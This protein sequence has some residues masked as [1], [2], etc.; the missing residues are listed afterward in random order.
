VKKRSPRKKTP[1]AR[2]GSRE[3]LHRGDDIEKFTDDEVR[4]MAHAIVD[5]LCGPAAEPVRPTKPATCPACG[6]GDVLRCV[7]SSPSG[8]PPLADDEIMAFGDCLQG[9]EPAWV[10]RVCDHTWGRFLEVTSGT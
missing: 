3:S 2:K 7:P 5:S 8:E 6:A 1:G 9:D 4:A 10:C